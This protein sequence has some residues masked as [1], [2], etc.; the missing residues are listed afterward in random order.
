MVPRTARYYRA[1]PVLVR[2]AILGVIVLLTMRAVQYLGYAARAT[3]FPFRLDY[4]EGSVWQQA[5]L[6]P[7]PQLYGDITQFP[8][9]VFN[10]PPVYHLA[11]RAI[12]ALQVDPLAAGRGVTLAATIAIALLVGG[13]VFA[14]MLEID[15]TI[16]RI[17]GATVASLMVLTYKPVQVWAT[18]MR[19]DMLAIAFS[20]GGIYFTIVAR[21]KTVTFCAAV[22]LFVLALYTKQTQL[23][24]PIAAILVATAVNFRS[25]SKAVAFGLCI[26]FIPFAILELE[27]NGG[28]WRHIVEYNFHNRF[29]F[30]ILKK[31]LYDQ[32]HNAIGLLAGVMTFGFLWWSEV[33]SHYPRNLRDWIRNIRESVR[34]RTL[35]ILSLWFIF[36]SAQLV[37]L[38]KEGASSNYLIEWMCI[39]TMPIGML[40]SIAW[41]KSVIGSRSALL[42]AVAGVFL[43]IALLEHVRYQPIWKNGVVD[44]PA[45]IASETRLVH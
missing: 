35:T 25:A 14:A 30:G 45:A 34:L 4:G 41:A 11:I 39:T 15:S 22:L 23:S 33:N 37:T 17:V 5:L 9:I 24:A 38:G 18:L 1:G 19:V 8:F 42:S 2:A 13:I 40:A 6:I 43:S 29:F 36:A 16:A 26:G 44:D 21:R 27:T 3:T 10:Y 7:G 12:S 31:N 32:R 28:F 20:M